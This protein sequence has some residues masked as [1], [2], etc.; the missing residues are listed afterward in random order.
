MFQGRIAVAALSVGSIFVAGDAAAGTAQLLSASDPCNA[1]LAFRVASNGRFSIGTNPDAATCSAGAGSYAISYGWPDRTG[2]SFTTVRVDGNDYIYGTDGSEVLAPVDLSATENMSDWTA[3]GQVHAIQDL[4]IVQGPS[5]NP[6]TLQV[7]Y[8]VFND[9]V[10]SHYV[11]MRI[12]LD[13]AIGA[14]DG[15]AIAA[16]PTVLTTGADYR[17]VFVPGTWQAIS[18]AS[19]TP[20]SA[21]GTLD[22]GPGSPDGFVVARWSDLDLTTYDVSVDQSASIAP[23]SAVAI[24][25]LSQPVAAGSSITFTTLYGLPGGGGSSGGGGGSAGPPLLATTGSAQSLSVAYD[26]K[27]DFKVT[28]EPDPFS[29]TG[30][31]QNLG[32]TTANN[33]ALTLSLGPDLSLASGSAS[34]SVG[35]LAPG[36]TKQVSWLISVNSLAAGNRTTNF[37]VTSTADNAGSSRVTHPLLLPGVGYLPSIHGYS[38]SNPGNYFPTYDEMASYYPASAFEMYMT[39]NILGIPVQVQSL[40]GFAFYQL[41][42]KPTYTVGLCY[43]MSSSDVTLYNTRALPL[44]GLFTGGISSPFPGA[45]PAPNPSPN[46]RDLLHFIYRYH[47][48]QLAEAGAASSA[49][50]LVHADAVGNIAIFNEIKARVATAPIWVALGPTLSMLPGQAKHWWDLYNNSHAVIAYRTKDSTPGSPRAIAVYD[51]N[52]PSDD[53]AHLLVLD[54]GGVQLLSAGSSFGFGGANGSA[55]DWRLMP[56]VDATFS[57]AG[58]FFSLDNRHWVLDAPQALPTQYVLNGYLGNLVGTPIIPVRDASAL[59]PQF[60]GQLPAGTGVDSTVTSVAPGMRVGELVSG[61][62]AALEQDPADGAGGSIAVR[63][64]PDASA[65]HLASPSA[66]AHVAASVGADFVPD[67]G[68]QMRISGVAVAPTDA[69]D[70]S[71]DATATSFTFDSTAP[72]PQTA[73]GTLQQV[74]N[75]AGSAT[76]TVVIPGQGVPAIVTSYDWSGLGQSLVWER[77]TVDGFTTALVLQDNLVQRRALVSDE[78]AR[79]QALVAVVAQAGIRNSLQAKLN[80]VQD[81]LQRGDA[82]GGLAVGPHEYVTAANVLEALRNEVSAQMG[83]A[84]ATAEGAQMHEACDIIRPMLGMIPDPDFQLSLEPK[85]QPLAPGAS[86]DY[87]VR[88]SGSASGISLRLGALPVGISGTLDRTLLRPGETARLTVTASSDVPPWAS[89]AFSVTGSSAASVQAAAAE[90]EITPVA[91]SSALSADRRIVVLPAGRTLALTLGAERTDG[92]LALTTG[93]LPR[94]LIASF[95]APTL[96]AGGRAVLTLAA[97][98]SARRGSFTIDVIGSSGRSRASIP[99]QIHVV[100]GGDALQPTGCSSAAAGWE[101]LILGAAVA[102]A[103]RSRKRRRFHVAS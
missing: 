80:Q 12:M 20:L 40:T 82:A 69:F 77:Y 58:N 22:V 71:G 37:T 33:A 14:D 100:E 90:V 79:L 50:E 11:G 65:L 88:T 18:G 81:H 64:A 54:D 66:M 41:I 45:I 87:A 30:S 13:T 6:D 103:S 85:S 17:G 9:D 59:S 72:A 38:F 60:L 93:N 57:E 7:Q 28:Y 32:A 89:G 95:S 34:R 10:K 70:L 52:A 15:P 1:F 53:T 61:R 67:R 39:V 42:F 98:P 44:N 91:D 99:I 19:G 63:I 51:P 101:A 26:A 31:V 2:T 47:S 49:A 75:Q 27:G 21:V 84:I 102:L 55:S 48:R 24:F 62:L 76:V 43:G 29:I 4:K 83:K 8:T 68:R 36:E 16:G 56:E 35:T 73:L 74:G 78:L 46:D 5:G 94:G 23:D 86:A 3:V 25:W 92:A 96:P 97:E